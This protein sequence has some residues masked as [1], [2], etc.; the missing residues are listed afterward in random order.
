MTRRAIIILCLL[1]SFLVAQSGWAQGVVKRVYITDVHVGSTV[2]VSVAVLD[3]E[4]AEMAGLTSA[5]FEVYED[6]APVTAQVVEERAGL[7]VMVL[8]DC[9]GSM[10]EPG[11][12][13][14]QTRMDSLKNAAMGFID[15]SLAPDDQVGVIG[16][17]VDQVAFQDLTT[18]HGAA[19]NAV[20]GL[21]FN[22]AKN[23]AL[24]N[25]ASQALETLREKDLGRMRKV[26]LIFSDGK[27]YL[28]KEDPVRYREFREAV[29]RKGR[30]YDIPIFVVGVGSYCGNNTTCVGNYPENEFNFE[31]VDWLADQTD[32]MSYHYTK[33]D[34]QPDLKAFFDRLTS[35]GMQYRL[36]YQTHAP[37]GDHQLR[38]RVNAGGATMEDSATLAT[39]FE[40]PKLELI[41]PVAGEV[42]TTGV[43]SVSW[44]V[45]PS[46]SDG[47]DRSLQE[48]TF[49]LNDRPV[50]TDTTQPY[51]FTWQVD[52]YKREE[53][54][55][56]RAT[57][58]DSILRGTQQTD[59][60]AVSVKPS[61]QQLFIN[62]LSDHAVSL[63]VGL[64]SIVLFVILLGVVVRNRKVIVP[65]VRSGVTQALNTVTQALGPRPLARLKVAQGG[66]HPG[67]EYRLVRP[68]SVIGRA[69]GDVVPD[70]GLT[71]SRNHATIEQQATTFY[72]T[73][74][75]STGTW[76][77]GTRLQQGYPYPLHNGAQ[78]RMGDVDFVFLVKGGT[79]QILSTG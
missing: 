38:V 44:E 73:D 24:L 60:R 33:L 54:F 77:D 39:P 6:N 55:V 76:V 21:T 67:R 48:V 11:V 10:A 58:E 34:Q 75:S 31:D 23:T 70:E 36:S 29:A 78:V 59:P 72:I 17:H 63:G 35:Q 27:D 50:Y 18:D 45:V 49:Y 22:P 30:E 61:G 43:G 46:F 66:L 19:R 51:T 68:V 16:F 32:G 9:S 12:A 26:M 53:Q 65:A 15:E 62:W 5:A 52:D 47:W 13:A 71:I 56:V 41:G 25:T 2:D 42:I 64:L 28:V 40:P 74:T 3:Q 57:A 1:L 8:I 4:M 79:T 37:K 7:A 14:G 69:S 20:Y